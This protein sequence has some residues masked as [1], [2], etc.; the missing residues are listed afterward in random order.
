MNVS[1]ALKMN[2]FKGAKVLA[3]RNGLHRKVSAAEVMEIPDISGWLS[4]GILI[5]ST[6]YSVK[7]SPEAQIKIFC[8]M[9]KNNSAGLMV[10]F[11][12]FIDQLPQEMYDLANEHDMPIILLPTDMPFVNVLS[13]LF[14]RI[15]VEREN[16]QNGHVKKISALMNSEYNTLNCLL[17]EI[18]A[19]TGENV[20]YE[21]HKY[22]LISFAN[23]KTDSYRDS[24]QLLSLPKSR[25]ESGNW[26]EPYK[27]EKDRIVL[28]VDEAG[29]SIGYLHILCKQSSVLKGVFK[30]FVISLKEQTKL[31]L[32]KE[33][34]KV[35]KRYLTEYHFLEH[36][37]LERRLLED[38][39]LMK[40][41]GAGQEDHL[42][43]L[44]GFFMDEFSDVL[45]YSL[46]KEIV[47]TFI[48]YRRLFELID[49]KLPATILYN[50][51][52]NL[53]GLYVCRDQESR[54]AVFENLKEIMSQFE[55]E[56]S[57]KMVGGISLPH[58]DILNLDRSLDEVKL[59][60]HTQME[61]G[62]KDHLMGYEETGLTKILLKLKNDPDIQFFIENFIDVL[63]EQEK[64][65]ELIQTLEMFL[66]ENGNHLKTSEKLF[67]HRRTLRHRLNKI[68]SLLKM[69]LDSS[70]NRFLLYFLL[71]MR[72]IHLA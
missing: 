48:I 17:E 61:T 22:R 39:S 9:I 15:H 4:E 40:R 60:I 7:N 20:Y 41:I 3:G 57:C 14:E 2:E 27:M 34:Y 63:A 35:Q 16:E 49:E 47:K 53:Y 8:T 38:E 59:A 11:G 10:K 31:L 67:I 55:R 70:E 21:D 12:R 28:Q 54:L 56:F 32:F 43:G 5:I 26:P 24:F 64:N 51:G 58:D 69:D 42:F 72:K 6:F 65:E 62:A 50:D 37:L 25:K 23:K 46:E 44:F 19:I 18:S 33:R 52:M 13:A 71:K 45:S 36:L 66:K 30:D 1:D 68:E 29:E